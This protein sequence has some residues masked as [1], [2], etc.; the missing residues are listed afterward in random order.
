MYK[1]LSMQVLMLQKEQYS[2][3]A[4]ICIVLN[5]LTKLV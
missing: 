3:V 4:C 2:E 1:N 5:A